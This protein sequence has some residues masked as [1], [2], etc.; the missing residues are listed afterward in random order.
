[1]QLKHPHRTDGYLPLAEYGALGDGRSVALVGSDGSIDWWCVPRL[2]SPPLLD[3]ILNAGDAGCFSITP[4]SKFSVTRAYRPN[5]NVLETVFKTETGSA[6]L[7]ESLNSG[8]AGRLP[9]SELARRIEGL[10]GIVTFSIIFRPGAGFTASRQAAEIPQQGV[11]FYVGALILLF[12][13]NAGVSILS[14]D[15]MGLHAVAETSPGS[16]HIVALL[17][18]DSAPLTIPDIDAV[19]HRIDIS[20]EAW[21][22]WSKRLRSIALYDAPV[23][24]SALALKLLLFSATGAIAAAG[25]TSLPEW[26]GGNKNYDYRFAWIRDSAYT[27]RAFLRVNAQE[28]VQAAFAWILSAIRK[29]APDLPVFLT[30]DAAIAPKQTKLPLSGYRSSRPVQ[31]GNDART[32]QQWS[33]FG[34]V[35]ET[36]WHFVQAGHVLDVTSRSVLADVADR[37]M[38]KWRWRDSGIWELKNKQHYTFSKFSCWLALDRACK[39]AES[40]HIDDSRHSYWERERNC[41]REWIDERCWSEEKQAYTEYAGSKTLDASLLLAACFGFDRKDRMEMTCRAVQRELRRGCFI[42]RYSGALKT[43][44]TFLACAF[45]MVEALAFLGHLEEAKQVMDTLLATTNFNNG[46]LNEMIDADTLEMMGNFPQ[47]LSH[48]ALIGAADA[49]DRAFSSSPKN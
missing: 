2:D 18:E 34:D 36:A 24:R 41:I 22:S 17:A 44:G 26:I 10:D 13:H 16:R 15:D 40:G 11:L 6:R 42:Y 43:E 35:V 29:H 21:V 14:R 39:L 7:T 47:G 9:W 27:A 25:T 45:W 32:Q 12:Q 5:S 37:C 30:L 4:N 8:T 23:R 3:R 20:D 46:L 33:T 38:R 31:R 28:E 1:M 48:L 19:D 49:I